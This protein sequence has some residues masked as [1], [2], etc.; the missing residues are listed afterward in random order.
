MIIT[1][2]I[3]KQQ[4]ERVKGKSK[5]RMCTDCYNASMREYRKR[6]R[7]KLIAKE[8]ERY[9]ENRKNPEWVKAEQQRHREH[10]ASLRHNAIMAYG[11]YKCACCGETE[12]KFLSIDHI[13]N[14]GAEHR[15]SMGYNENGKGASSATLGWLKRHNYPPGFQVLCMNCNHGRARNNGVCPHKGLHNKTA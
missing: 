9:R 10:W 3:C 4:K 14:D 11:G 12:P 7:N 8:K 2:R 6:N 13:N 1:C 15:R 5:R